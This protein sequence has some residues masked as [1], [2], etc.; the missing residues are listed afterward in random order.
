MARLRA[1]IAA[2]L[3]FALFLTPVWGAASSENAIGTVV[4]SD[5]AN[6]GATGASVG[7]TV[8]GGDRLSTTQNGSVQVR[9]G[10]A[11]F[12]LSKASI[13]TL[14]KEDG[15]SGANLTLGSATFSTA[16]SKA[17]TLHVASAVIRPNTDGPTVGQ[18]T[19]LNAKE[20]VIKSTRGSLNITVDDD[21]RVVAEG[22]AYHVVLDSSDTAEPQGPAGAGTKGMGGPP[23]KAGK[24]K[25]IWYAIA[26]TAVA[27]VIAVHAALESPD[28]P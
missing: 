23:I 22:A 8:F 27:T 24:S 28:R 6:V 1:S 2:L 7:S 3:S 20:F 18:V 26:I 21:S 13:A 5:G 14:M 19:V 25:F 12:L 9:A 15:M 10:A 4:Y 11:R 17:F 16:N